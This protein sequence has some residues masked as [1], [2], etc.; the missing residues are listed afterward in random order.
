MSS[1]PLAEIRRRFFEGE[2]LPDNSVPSP[3]LHSWRRCLGL[4][5][6]AARLRL[7]DKLDTASLGSRQQENAD[8]LQLAR[9]AIDALFD[10]VVDDGHVVIVADRHGVILDQMGHPAFLDR[11]ERVALLP[12]MDWREDVRGTNAIGTALVLGGPVRV[13]GSEHYLERNRQ[14]SCTAGAIVSPQGELLGVVD[15]SGLPRK[16]GDAQ[17]QQVQAAVRHIEQ[18]LF[19]EQAGALFELRFAPDAATLT[20]PRCGRLGFDD[21]GVLRAANRAALATLGLDWPALGHSRF[22]ALAGQSLEHWLSRHGIGAASLRHGGQLYSARLLPPTP[23]Q[24]A[25]AAVP[26]D[27]AAARAGRAADSKVGRN[28]AGALPDGLLQ[29]GQRLL[30]ADIPVLVLGETG[31]GKERFVQALHAA[32]SRA[33]APL[34][35]VNCAAIPEGLIEAELFGYEEGAFTG[36]RKQGAKGRLREADG[37]ILFLDEIGDMPASLQAR[38]LRVLQE[39]LVVPLGGG[40]GQKVDVRIVAAT[41]R[42]L[43][44][45]VAAGRFRAD[46]YYRLGHYP[47]RLPPLRERG[48]VAQIAANLLAQHGGARRGVT[49]SAAL[50]DFIR[51]YPWPGNLRQLDNLLKTLL[52]LVDDGTELGLT[53]LPDTLREHHPA[54]VGSAS[55]G[56]LAQ[57]LQQHGGNA[58]AAARALGISRS[59]FYRRLRQG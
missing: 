53:H 26:A 6:S 20:T 38:L 34:V 40:I 42:N 13:R 15:V 30:E 17:Q 33:G 48:D 12:G 59:T 43:E 47:L 7:P 41:H 1:L 46:L 35:A 50:A 58:S 19:D 16:L 21:D 36:A 8:W 25:P 55:G 18:R 49:L 29:R 24:A 37:G 56:Q 28:D 10:S 51:R 44:H 39:R 4:G 45:E 23:R 57:L 22:A 52:A 32:S 27:H 9:P 31:V 5:L 2:T 3:I 54:A 14:L 11:A